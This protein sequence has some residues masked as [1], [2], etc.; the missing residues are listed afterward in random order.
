MKTKFSVSLSKA[1]KDIAK[2]DNYV[3]NVGTPKKPLLYVGEV[4]KISGS[5]ITFRYNGSEARGKLIE[6]GKGT[7]K[8]IEK[9][10]RAKS[11][12]SI[13]PAV[14]QRILDKQKSLKEPEPKSDPTHKELTKA[15]KAKLFDSCSDEW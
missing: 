7:S 1:E 15:K 3:I 2:G 5:K 11:H 12:K 13:N 4:T 8:I 9:T 14:A 10:R 6:L